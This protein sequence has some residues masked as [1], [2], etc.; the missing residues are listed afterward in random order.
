M[1]K[2]KIKR[3]TTSKISSTEIFSL[4]VQLHCTKNGGTDIGEVTLES[5]LQ[6]ILDVKKQVERQFSIPVC[7]QTVSYTTGHALRNDIKLLDLK[8]RNGDTFHVEYLAKADCT[9]IM[10]II[11][12]LEQLSQAMACESLDLNDIAETGVQKKIIEKLPAYWNDLTSSSYMNKL[13]FIHNHGVIE[14]MKVYDFLL[15]KPWNQMNQNFKYLECWIIE[16]LGFF[17][18]TA[19]LC[20]LLI[21]HNVIPMITQSLLRV[22]LEEGRRIAEYNISGNPLEESYLVDTIIGSIRT[23]LK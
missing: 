22:R 13:H 8:V 14:I 7:V 5:P 16:S 19:P 6:D 3:N 18:E 9:G 21:Q 20:Q 23:L 2:L 4:N 12:W 15:Q 10:E 17:A 11:S 1:D